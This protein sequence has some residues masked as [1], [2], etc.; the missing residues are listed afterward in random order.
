MFVTWV[1]K[2]RMARAALAVIRRCAHDP[3]I[4]HAMIFLS[5]SAK[6]PQ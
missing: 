3:D 5:R 6:T 2:W 4:L 1:S